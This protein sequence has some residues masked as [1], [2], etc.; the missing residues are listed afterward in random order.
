MRIKTLKCILTGIA[1][2]AAVA[3]IIV[4]AAHLESLI[5]APEETGESEGFSAVTTT[6]RQDE[7][8]DGSEEEAAREVTY[9]NGRA[10][11]LN[12]ALSTMLIMGI[13]DYELTESST[14]RNTS[15]ADFLLL[16]VFDSE[17][18]TCALLQI[19]RDTMADVPVLGALGNYIGLTT[20]QIAL[21][22]TY[23]SGL[24]DSCENTVQAV[25]RF[26]YGINIEHYMSL[27]MDA[28]A[29]LNDLVG[30]VT[31][32]I[33]D[34]FTGVDDT[35]VQGETV[36]LLGDHALHFVRAR[37]SMTDD[38]TNLARMARQRTYMAAL[39]ESLRDAVKDDAGFVLSAFSALSDY[40]VT[41]CD[42]YDLSDLG[43]QLSD[44]SLSDIVTPEGEAV[45][46]E[47]Y[48]EF[49]VDEDALQELVIGLFYLPAEE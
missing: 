1:V 31:V 7:E 8:E 15:Q 45:L 41:D 39:T 2:C 47:K 6:V 27:T 38:D 18:E 12:D 10:Y 17:K 20:E 42:I 34:D 30:G 23:G 4:L 43:Q 35:L 16:A 22:H 48:M 26:L 24:E 19:N 49:Y 25:S 21:A 14:Y 13:D 36:T 28:V 9:Y 37:S 29:I 11:V 5:R 33:E 46:G 32:T 40:L 3:L 44:Y